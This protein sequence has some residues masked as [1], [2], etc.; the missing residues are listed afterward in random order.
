MNDRQRLKHD[1]NLALRTV[2]NKDAFRALW[3]SLPAFV[4]LYDQVLAKISYVNACVLIQGS[5]TTGITQAKVDARTRMTESTLEVA[6]GLSALA[7]LRGDPVLEAKAEINPSKIEELA[8]SLV[9]DKATEILQLARAIQPVQNQPGPIDVGLTEGRLDLLETRIETY[10]LLLGSPRAAR[11]EKTA[12]TTKLQVA[13]DAID[14]L[15]EKGLDK[16]V[17][18]F[19]STDFY[20][21]YQLARDPVAV[22]KKKQEI[23]T[24]NVGS[25]IEK[26]PST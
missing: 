8:D 16:L 25:Q 23:G 9:D 2:C 20:P 4:T 26:K 13:L 14:R 1:S 11:G 10:N 12:A 22:A 21:E 17:L 24:G 7:L 5:K 3:S 15:L 19:K 18:Q 6:G